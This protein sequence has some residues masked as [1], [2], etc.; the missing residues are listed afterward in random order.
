MLAIILLGVFGGWKLDE[1][2]GLKKPIFTV[3][4]SILS[5]VL[6]IYSVVRDLLKKK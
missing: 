2:L 5:V 4:F 1:Y 3:V 6:S